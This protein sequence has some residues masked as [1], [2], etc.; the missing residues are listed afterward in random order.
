M[1]ESSKSDREEK[2]REP[3]QMMSNRKYRRLFF[4][5]VLVFCLL[6][7]GVIFSAPDRLHNSDTAE[8]NMP[9]EAQSG[10]LFEFADFN[11]P[12]SHL[13]GRYANIVLIRLI[14]K[15]LG[16]GYLNLKIMALLVSLATLLLWMW[17]LKTVFNP[18]TALCFALLYTFSPLL[19]FKWSL[20]V[21]GAYPESAL[22]VAVVFALIAYA[23]HR[24]VKKRY[25]RVFF[26]GVAAGLAISYNI[27]NVTLPILSVLACGLVG[28]R[29]ERLLN[30]LTCLVGIRVGIIPLKKY[31]SYHGMDALTFHPDLIEKAGGVTNIFNQFLTSPIE[32]PAPYLF[33]AGAYFDLFNH[34]PILIIMAIVSFAILFSAP[35][36]KFRPVALLMPIGV[37]LLPLMFAFSAIRESF[38]YRHMV[39][40]VPILY[41]CVSVAIT[42]P[43]ET[44]VKKKIAA[45]CWRTAMIAFLAT[46]CLF[47]A[48]GIVGLITPWHPERIFE[49]HALDYE[50]Y[51]V[52]SAVGE[53]LQR[54]NLAIDSGRLENESFLA[55]FQI[56]F[57][58]R[59]QYGCCIKNPLPI[60][61]VTASATLHAL[62]A[63]DAFDNPDVAR[64]FGYGVAVKKYDAVAFEKLVMQPLR[65]N[66]REGVAEWEKE[67]CDPR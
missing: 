22:F 48:R 59:G 7:V 5:I 10:G 27:I 64:G 15:I 32:A 47:G 56:A 4:L 25:K 28:V 31:I 44:F 17:T 42:V 13:Q 35:M 45:A 3:F 65:D 9:A 6:R 63:D 12:F 11:Y 61:P 21:W 37:L 18:F 36:S 34:N 1:E 8:L 33:L 54:L 43:T 26:V 20:M 49:F 38:A 52:G 40:L 24:P 46:W 58:Q 57:P 19:Y 50:Q 29:K 30:L 53:E 39:P 23:F 16:F 66:F 41:A 2:G 55:G 51:S 62:F 14:G 60:V 67:T